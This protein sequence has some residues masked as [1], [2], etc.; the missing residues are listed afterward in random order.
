MA[1]SVKH[2]LISFTPLLQDSTLSHRQVNLGAIRP[3]CYFALS[4]SDVWQILCCRSRY[5][6]APSPQ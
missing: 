6:L 5:H 1:E 4:I 2:S 3:C